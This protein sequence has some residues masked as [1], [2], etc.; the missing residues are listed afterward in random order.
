MSDRREWELPHLREAHQLPGAGGDFWSVKFY[1]YTEPGVDPVFAVVGGK[2]ASLPSRTPKCCMLMI[3]LQILV[4]RPPA[5]KESSSRIEI[6]QLI[7]DEEQEADHF[8]CA[9]SKDLETGDPLLCVSGV[10]AK[11]KIINVLTGECLRTLA[12]HGGEVNDLVVSPVNPYILASAS[13]DCT[14]RVWSLDPAHERQPCAAILEGDGHKETVLTLSFHKNGRYLIS[15]GIDHVINLWTLPEFPDINTGTNK[16][17]RIFY[18]HFS[19]SEIHSDIVDCVAWHGDLILSKAANEDSIALW[20]INAFDSTSPPPPPSTAPTTHDLTR[21]TRSAFAPSSP[22]SPNSP[23]ALYTRHLQFS[24]PESAIIFMRFSLFP[25]RPPT[26]DSPQTNSSFSSDNP[27]TT[28]SIGANPIL[29]FCNT[30]SKVFFWD[31]TRL[32]NY[33]DTLSQFPSEETFSPP[34]KHPFLQPFQ[35]RTR[36]GGALARLSRRSPSPT[37]S[38]SSHIT[39]SDVPDSSYRDESQDGK[40]KEKGNGKGKIDWNRS[41]ENWASKY[42]MGD[43]LREIGA[44][45][46][47]V[48]KGLS[49]T[50]RQVAWSVDGR[51]CVVVG[52]SGVVACLQRWRD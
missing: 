40:G 25:G 38:T 17:T 28:N 19:T 30:A 18:P 41:R 11:I 14:V 43:P 9:W 1:P 21:D 5:G 47:E 50:G 34:R 31:F 22:S 42:D 46:T 12:G 3:R 6:I 48:V 37:E 2:R 23:T 24:I 27:S 39:T 13:D 15:G 20:S 49:F 52:S 36:G 51:W 29:A 35:R 33:H 7:I 26:S 10:N 16:A 32:E 4:C 8:A 44:H 45:G